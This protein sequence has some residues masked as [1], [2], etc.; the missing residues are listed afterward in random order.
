VGTLPV[1]VKSGIVLHSRAG[2]SVS[3]I[4]QALLCPPRVGGIKRWCTSDIC[5]P[6]CHAH[7]A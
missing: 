4:N 1:A 3:A 7:M 2:L 6:V 5:L